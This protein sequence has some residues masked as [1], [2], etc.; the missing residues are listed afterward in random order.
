MVKPGDTYFY[1]WLKL[2]G[3]RSRVRTPSEAPLYQN[4]KK[5]YETSTVGKLSLKVSDLAADLGGRFWTT[6]YIKFQNFKVRRMIALWCATFGSMFL[7]Y[8]LSGYGTNLY[9]VGYKQGLLQP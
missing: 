6:V 3:G 1:F 7:G 5:F 8:L 4:I 2:K 9:T